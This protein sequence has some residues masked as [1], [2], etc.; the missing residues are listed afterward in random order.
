MMFSAADS[1]TQSTERSF[2][3]LKSGRATVASAWT[4]GASRNNDSATYNG[5][6]I[7]SSL[8]RLVAI[9]DFMGLPPQIFISLRSTR[10]VSSSCAPNAKIESLAVR[11]NCAMNCVE[12]FPTRSQITF[13]GPPKSTLRS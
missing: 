9:D 4:E 6:S 2:D 12:Q 7:G 13:G 11:N 3:G 5:R 1:P 8:A 10:Q